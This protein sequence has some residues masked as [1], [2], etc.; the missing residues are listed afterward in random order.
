MSL[1][2]IFEKKQEETPVSESGIPH[3]EIASEWKKQIHDRY[4]WTFLEKGIHAMNCL[5]VT[6]SITQTKAGQW[7]LIESGGTTH[8]DGYGVTTP[9]DLSVIDDHILDLK[10]VPH[11]GYGGSI[12]HYG[13]VLD[14]KNQ[15]LILKSVLGSTEQLSTADTM[16]CLTDQYAFVTNERQ[17]K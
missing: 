11:R 10:D 15:Q 1:F 4:Y 2:D 13:Y 8:M 17:G 9:I 16:H 7:Q 6:Y 14:L 3:R 5:Y 12:D